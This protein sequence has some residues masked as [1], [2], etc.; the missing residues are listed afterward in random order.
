MGELP[1]SRSTPQGPGVPWALRPR[2]PRVDSSRTSRVLLSRSVISHFT[3][4]LSPRGSPP[5]SRSPFPLL[6]I[7]T[8]SLHGPIQ[9]PPRISPP[10]FARVSLRFLPFPCVQFSPLCSPRRFQFQSLFPFHA[11][12]FGIVLCLGFGFPR[13]RFGFAFPQLPP[14]FPPVSFPFL[15]FPCVQFSPVFSTFVLFGSP[16]VFPPTWRS[17]SSPFSFRIPGSTAAF[18][19]LGF[20]GP[21]VAPKRPHTG[22]KEAAKFTGQAAVN[23][24]FQI[25]EQYSGNKGHRMLI[26]TV[27]QTLRSSLNLSI[28]SFFLAS[29]SKFSESALRRRESTFTST[30]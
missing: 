12:L 15:P 13:C 19:R 28:I 9:L 27:S 5:S 4:L 18:S 7:L 11:Y 20:C 22:F 23:K 21:R 6:A 3:H 25:L 8:I 1:P 14:P 24:P 2:F 17:D 29:S 30:K 26:S 10:L 16:V